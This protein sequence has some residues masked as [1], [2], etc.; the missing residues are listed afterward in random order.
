MR[1]VRA[2]FGGFGNANLRVEI[3]AVHINLAA[4]VV[5]NLTRLLHPL[6]VHAMCRRVGDHE[7]GEVVAIR[8]GLCLQVGNIDI[9]VVVAGHQHNLHAD[10]LRAGGISPMRRRRNE[11]DIALRVAAAQ[12]IFANREEAGVFAL[13]TGIWLHAHCI[14]TG[15]RFEHCLELGDHLQVAGHLL[16]R[17]KRVWF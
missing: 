7:R 6:F 2:D 9:A 3:R 13:R 12:V 14:E 4:V 16:D 11:A 15:D 10:H 5:N 17:R 8:F 1:H